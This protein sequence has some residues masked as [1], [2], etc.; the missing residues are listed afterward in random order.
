MMAV[1]A[2]PC[3]DAKRVSR[4]WTTHRQRLDEVRVKACSL[5]SPDSQVPM[6]ICR[7]I[8]YETENSDISF[9]VSRTASGDNTIMKKPPSFPEVATLLPFDTRAVHVSR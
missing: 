2:N 3:T 5:S 4:P 8:R 6:P 7:C 9:C 1:R